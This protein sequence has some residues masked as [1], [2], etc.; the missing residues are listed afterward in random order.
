MALASCFLSLLILTIC[1]DSFP[2]GTSSQV[3]PSS[4]GATEALRSSSTRDPSSMH[5]EDEDDLLGL[6]TADANL[7]EEDEEGENLFDGN[8]LRDYRAQPEMD[9]YEQVGLD[10]GDY[11]AMNAEERLAAEEILAARE[12]ERGRK[13][14]LPLALL[15]SD[16]DDLRSPRRRSRRRRREGQ[17]DELSGDEDEEEEAPVRLDEFQ[18]PISSWIALDSTRREVARR[19]R[20]FLLSFT[21]RE[22]RLPVYKERIHAMCTAQSRSLLVS[23]VHLSRSVPLLAM[24]V[25]DIPAQMLEIF[26]EVTM[27]V[28]LSMFKNYGEIYSSI[29]V[30]ITD[31]P[32]PDSLRDIRQAHLNTLIRIRG[33]V[34]RRSSVF[35]QLKL[36]K[37]DCLKCGFLIG[38]IYQNSTSEI[39]LG[40]CP[41]C[42]SRGPFAVNMEQTVY[43][44]FQKISV[45]ESPGTVPAGRVPRSKDVIVLQDLIDTVR[46]G[47][48]VDLT[49]IYTNNYE[50]SLNVRQGF[51]VFSTVIEANHIELCERGPSLSVV[52]EDLAFFQQLSA[53]PHLL[54]ILTNSVAPSIHGHDFIKTGI[55]LSLFGGQ[56]KNVGGKHR[57][58][59]DINVLLLGDPGTAKSQF[60][61]YLSQTAPRAVFTT[62]QGASAVGLTAS[63][64]KDAVTREWTLEGGA[65]VLSDGGMCLIDE[66]DK[67]NDTDRTSIHEAMEQQSISVSKAGIVTSLQ[68]RCSVIAAANPIKGRYDPTLTFNHNTELTEPILS[69]FDLLC[70]VRDIVN[71][72][73][74]ANLASFVVGS[75][76]TSL[77]NADVSSSGA[78]SGDSYTYPTSLTP[79]T[80]IS[81]ELLRKYIYHARS[82]CSPKLSH[83][84]T[85]RISSVYAQLRRE[86]TRVDGIPI[87]VRHVESIIRMSEASCRMHLREF[88][89]E[90]DV[91]LALKMMIDSFVSTQKYS[92]M[93][94][95]KR[96]F[97]NFLH[98]TEDTYDL[99]LFALQECIRENATYAHVRNP[100]ETVSTDNIA[101]AV[102]ELKQ[103][104]ASFGVTN[105]EAFLSSSYLNDHGF[106]RTGQM[107]VPTGA[108]DR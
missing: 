32:V 36:V 86:S 13:R 87:T 39:K 90:S 63:V 18:Q 3:G 57:L 104:V 52:S 37:Y 71:P 79:T 93:N 70:V 12:R 82:S 55:L 95:M 10:S 19:Y 84:S 34:T 6:H 25:A 7:D 15:T 105:V 35:P 41:S 69:R 99:C 88:V 17:L 97:A 62:G 48:E 76:R 5:E 45:Q 89:Q 2:G 107:V 30:R 11:D 1:N 38:P 96:K 46:P 49:G 50:A 59:G 61:S 56:A 58:R 106:T 21:D 28:V 100:D 98:N 33:V 103:K 102:S 75:H 51:P 4:P 68:A 92:V 53:S 16:D 65:L 27:E 67:M 42:Q 64:H 72:V 101:V 108:N 47:Q 8:E 31:L 80:R 73:V 9:V 29:S 81:Q 74:D 60:L 78:T 91:D 85:E 66:F 40:S 54:K 83:I 22:D 44:N 94:D 43:R 77:Q 26:D 24:W 20:L 23:F 14:A